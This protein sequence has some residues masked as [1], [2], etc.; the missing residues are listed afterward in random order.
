MEDE[1][2]TKRRRGL[3]GWLAISGL[4]VVIVLAV[5]GEVVAHRAEPILKGRVIETLSTRFRSKVELDKFNVS[6]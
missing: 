1:G 3:W 2:K 4:I 6:V 5:I